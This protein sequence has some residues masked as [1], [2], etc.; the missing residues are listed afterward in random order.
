MADF[1]R[2]DRFGDVHHEVIRWTIRQSAAQ[3]RALFETFSPFLALSPD[4]RR[5]VLDDIE[6]T[7]TNDFGA[8]VE[9]D[10]LTPIYLAPRR[11]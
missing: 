5:A 10:Y 8:M 9:R 7:V 2:V 11:A 1:E 6:A 3:V 4:L